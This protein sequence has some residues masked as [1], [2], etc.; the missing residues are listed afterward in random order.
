MSEEWEK[1]KDGAYDAAMQ[2]LRQAQDALPDF[3]SSYDSEIGRL[4][5]QITARREFRYDAAADPLYG[6]YRDRYVSDG[7]MAMRDT[8]GQAAALTGGYG[9][10]Y[11]QRVGQQQYDA[12]LQK[13]SAVM[14]QL[15]S[16]AYGRY[17]DEGERLNGQLDTAVKLADKEY[18][19][20]K[21]KRDAAGKLEQ[22]VYNRR[23]DSYQS[24]TSLI[25]KTGYEPNDEEL[26]RAGMSKEQAQALRHE[27][28]RANKLLPA[29][30]AGGVRVGYVYTGTPGKKKETKEQAS[31]SKEQA[32]LYANRRGAGNSDKRRRND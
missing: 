23:R 4:Y 6:M 7:R 13:L 11:A 16:A 8:M 24:L 5:E 14:P 21:D 31:E 30:N 27:Y 12:Y 29:A 22:Q 17:Q 10:S 19:R 25:S 9:S 28:L 26:A 18:G 32:M 20:E 2:A 3:T 15:Y 1:E